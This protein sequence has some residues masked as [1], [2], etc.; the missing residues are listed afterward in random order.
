M[1]VTSRRVAVACLVVAVLLPSVAAA[2]NPNVNSDSFRPSVHPGDILGITTAALP[3][4]LGFSAGVWMTWNHRPLKFMDP[5]GHQFLLVRDQVVADVVGSLSLF[6]FLDVGLDLPIF[7]MSKGDVPPA[8]LGLRQVSGAS[9][10][11]VRLGLK[12]SLLKSRPGGFGL[13]LAE[14]LTFPTS[15]PD[16]YSGDTGVTGTTTIVG[17]WAGGGWRVA[18]NVGARL[19][20]EVVFGVR[21][22]GHELL[23]GAG[24]QAPLVCGLLE[25]LGTI[26]ART[27]F[28]RAFKDRYDASLDLMGGL[29]LNWRH[30]AVVAA[31]GAGT[32]QGYGSPVPRVTLQVAYAPG[33]DSGCTRDRDHDG[34]RDAIDECPDE[35]G[36]AATGGCPDRDGDGIPDRDDRCPDAA[37]SARFRGCPDRDGDG[38]PDVDDACPDEPGPQEFKGCPDRDGD[39]IP[40]RDDR[41]P[42]VKGLPAWQGCPPPEVKVQDTRLELNDRVEFDVDQ[43]TLRPEA[44]PILDAVAKALVAHPEIK[45]V[46]IEGHTDNTASA[47][48]NLPLSERRAET[49]LKY[50]VDHGVAAGR[51]EAKGYGLTRPIADNATEEGRFQNR[52]VEF[53]I[54]ER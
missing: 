19:R 8:G 44:F 27:P 47:D 5:N 4:H 1:N 45:K 50:L 28:A 40:D 7:L 11:D 17:D 26:E 38:I 23:L 33:V 13:A 18:L 36:P 52:R 10:G 48:Y 31:A 24:F 2:E 41:C 32:L 15:H 6:G 21:P 14:D 49:V 22:F 42:D 37:G 16:R 20:K 46:R 30:L 29:R 34:I 3:K 39:G 53:A 12:A 35:P 54:I 25:A 9:V 43:A 51:L